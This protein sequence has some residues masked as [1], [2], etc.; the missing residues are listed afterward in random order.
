[1]AIGYFLVVVSTWPEQ[2]KFLQLRLSWTGFA[3][4]LKQNYNAQPE[5]DNQAGE[6]QHQQLMSGKTISN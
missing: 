6:S 5:A 1:M 3:E 2:P 4:M